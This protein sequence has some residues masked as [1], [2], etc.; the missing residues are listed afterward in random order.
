MQQPPRILALWSAPR[1]RSTA[2]SRMV[3]ERGDY[4]VI[5]EPFSR[6]AD[7]GQVRIGE[8]EVRSEAGVIAALRDVASRQPVFFKDTTDFRYPQ[9][10][11]DR[12]FLAEVRHSFIIREPAEAIASHFRLNPD[13]RCDDVGFTRLAELFD[14]VAGL[15]DRPPAVIDANELLVAPEALVRSYCEQVGIEFRPEALRWSAGM[16]ADWRQTSEWHAATSS[17]TGFQAPPAED[18]VDVRADE[19]LAGYLEHHL[20]AFQ[21]LHALRLRPAS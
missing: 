7:F 11:A 15:S 10:L 5:H 8:R 2:F 3:A 9:V 4:L 19:T 1:C 12:D 21:R 13:L 18:A 16:R 14:A 6:L 17:T 20:P